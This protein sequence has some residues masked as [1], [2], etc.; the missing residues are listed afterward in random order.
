MKTINC[1]ADLMSN[2]HLV[3]PPDVVK[4]I[5][6]NKINFKSTKKRI[7]ILNDSTDSNH[8]NKF[9]GKWMDDSDADEIVSDIR[10]NREK[11][12]RSDRII[13]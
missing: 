13:F 8:L 6:N 3:L 11:N 7:I 5:I 9:C 2:G 12:N 10:L 4:I 1:E